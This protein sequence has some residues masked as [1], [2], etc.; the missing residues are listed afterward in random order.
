MQMH[1]Q[2]KR[3]KKFS[4]ST[5]RDFTD[6]TTEITVRVQANDAHRPRYSIS[7]GK[8]KGDFLAPHLPM[9][10]TVENGKINAISDYA[11][12]VTRLLDEARLFITEKAQIRE[13]EIMTER[14]AKEE[15]NT[16]KQ[17]ATMGLKNLSKADA[18]KRAVNPVMAEGVTLVPNDNIVPGRP[19]MISRG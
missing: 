10:I 6:A 7:I 11:E 19:I 3:E 15:R 8:V 18:A 14:I 9:Y 5:L 16:H 1:N 2:D 17:A 13:D 4:W 12:V